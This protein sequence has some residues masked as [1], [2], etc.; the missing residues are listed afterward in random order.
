MYKRLG[1]VVPGSPI[2]AT[3]NT[4]VTL[5]SVL[6]PILEQNVL[7]SM[8]KTVGDTYKVTIND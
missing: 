7:I 1:R 4:F 6:N 8:S 3:L 2:L 5:N